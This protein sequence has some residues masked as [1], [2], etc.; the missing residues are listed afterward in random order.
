M[1]EL[2]I[3]IFLLACLAI[4]LLVGSKQLNDVE[5]LKS[6]KGFSGALV[7][8]SALATNHSAFI[9]LGQIGFAYTY[10]PKVFILAAAWKVGDL[11]GMFWLQS[12]LKQ[13]IDA[14]NIYSI[15]QLIGRNKKNLQI[16][17]GVFACI[18]LM[19]YASAQYG[20]LVKT[21]SFYSQVG[22]VK[23]ILL[24]FLIMAVYLFRGGFKASVLTDSLQFLIIFFSIVVLFSEIIFFRNDEGMILNSLLGTY[25]EFPFPRAWGLSLMTI[26]W[27]IGGIGTIAQPQVL[28]RFMASKSKTELLKAQWV[29]LFFSTITTV[30]VISLGLMARQLTIGQGHDPE[31][32]LF[33]VAFQS[34]F[35][36]LLGLTLFLGVLSSV[37][38]T[39]DSLVLSITSI[40]EIDIKANLKNIV[41]PGP[42]M[43]T[44]YALILIIPFWYFGIRSDLFGSPIFLDVYRPSLSS[45]NLDKNI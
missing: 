29:Y 22:S 25:K 27:F 23:L 2:I 1:Q 32:S 37:M 14:E 18:A 42:R 6:K 21:L 10:G 36:T 20:A 11:F 35:S 19:L 7:G 33:I 38:S 44:L 12:R 15:T 5:F 4:C 43:M 39:M 17:I 9:Y 45:H 3:S 41:L 24:V 13:H 30:L 40:F 28:M 26:G 8:I 31:V 34:Q 16:T